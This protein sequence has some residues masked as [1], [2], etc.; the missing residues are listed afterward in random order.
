MKHLLALSLGFAATVLLAQ[1]K[2]DR[3][4]DPST[5][6]SA[7]LD[8][9]IATGKSPR[10]LAQYVFDPH[11]CNNCHTIGHDG[12]LGYTETGKQRAQGY[13]GCI[14]LLTAMTVVVQVPEDK[15]S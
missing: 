12:K 7:V 2:Q 4:K 10:E 8:Q 3:K 14:D 9:M 6:E 15:R 13:E 5:A 1:Q 11:G